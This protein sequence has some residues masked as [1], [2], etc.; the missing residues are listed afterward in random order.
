MKYKQ[1]IAAMTRHELYSMWLCYGWAKWEWIRTRVFRLP[2]DEVIAEAEE[3]EFEEM[4]ERIV[5]KI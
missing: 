5:G 1:M 2:Q 3:A 4:L